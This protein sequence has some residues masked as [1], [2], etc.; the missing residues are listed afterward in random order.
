MLE[1]AYRATLDGMRR[2]TERASQLIRAT[3]LKQKPAAD[4]AAEATSGAA[5]EYTLHRDFDR[6]L[7]ALNQHVSSQLEKVLP[8]SEE[9]QLA[10]LDA[11]AF[12]PV[13]DG[14]PAYAVRFEAY[15][16][17]MELLTPPSGAAPKPDAPDALRARGAKYMGPLRQEFRNAITTMIE[18]AAAPGGQGN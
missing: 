9:A 10:D 13:N 4:A 18:A 14:V 1:S 2:E 12:N 16:L 17:G 8:P 6:K 11:S 7:A 5:S 3:L 15:A